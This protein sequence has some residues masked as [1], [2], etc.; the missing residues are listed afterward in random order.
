VL[1]AYARNAIAAGELNVR[2]WVADDES[3]F[4][5]HVWTTT[6]ASNVHFYANEFT[7]GKSKITLQ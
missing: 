4:S 2:G 5:P 7:V 3:V 1:F 6:T